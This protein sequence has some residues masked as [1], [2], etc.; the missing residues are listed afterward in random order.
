MFDNIVPRLMSV[1]SIPC[2]T[3]WRTLRSSRH[4]GFRQQRSQIATT[5]GET[6]K[7]FCFTLGLSFPSTLTKRNILLFSI[8]KTKIKLF[9]LA[10]GKS[11]SGSKK[12]T[13]SMWV[14]ETTLSPMFAFFRIIC[15]RQIRVCSFHFDSLLCH[16][17][18]QQREKKNDRG[19]SWTRPKVN[20]TP[21]FHFPSKDGK[22]LCVL[23]LFRL[24]IAPRLK[25]VDS[26]SE[27]NPTEIHQLLTE[28]IFPSFL[29][30]A[31]NVWST[32]HENKSNDFISNQ[33][34]KEAK[35]GKT[36]FLR[37]NWK[38]NKNKRW[39]KICIKVALNFS[40]MRTS[41]EIS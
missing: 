16:T 9:G 28:K 29:F 39:W 33:T 41:T 22:T 32:F 25:A 23:F 37:R 14:R 38:K 2:E 3:R 12:E 8:T 6:S 20:L 30:L 17:K 15:F 31:T 35:E 13:C 10:E 40:T 4:S 24:E 21:N 19:C 7:R 36:F 27:D 18:K 5:D 26:L 34:Q 1:V 11:S